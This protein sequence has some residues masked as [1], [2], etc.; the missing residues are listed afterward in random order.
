MFH[1]VR[2]GYGWRDPEGDEMVVR[3]GMEEGEGW[4]LL[5]R[6]YPSLHRQ[7]RYTLPD[8]DLDYHPFLHSA[9]LLAA[10]SPPPYSP[11][12]WSAR[13]S[14]DPSCTAPP[15]SQFCHSYRA[16]VSLFPLHHLFPFLP[17]RH[18]LLYPL[19]S[20][21]GLRCWRERWVEDLTLLERRGASSPT[22]RRPFL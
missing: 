6:S 22:S 2:S 19:C 9:H 15:L 10:D 21:P 1:R 18:D 4:S 3:Q 5:N 7:L 12:E 14:S 11:F 17:L 8:L 13:H 16:Q 20:L